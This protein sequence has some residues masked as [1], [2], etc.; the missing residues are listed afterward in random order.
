[1]IRPPRGNQLAIG[2]GTCCRL[3]FF[4][5]KQYF[6]LK[7]KVQVLIRQ[8]L[9]DGKISTP[10]V[11]LDALLSNTRS[12]MLIV[13]PILELKYIE[14]NPLRYQNS[15]YLGER[16]IASQYVHMRLCK[17]WRN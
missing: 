5:P 3:C 7:Q 17:Y 15:T 13:S 10:P 2:K 11:K 6:R 9:L 16:A 4:R 14:W 1:M 8:T 12:M